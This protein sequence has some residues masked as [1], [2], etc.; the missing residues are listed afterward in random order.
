MLAAWPAT[1]RL[2]MLAIYGSLPDMTTRIAQHSNDLPLC[3]R[4]R[5]DFTAASMAGY[6]C[7]AP[8][9]YCGRLP[10]EYQ[11][12]FLRAIYAVDFY[13]VTSYSTPIA[14]YAKGVWTVP[15]VKYT[16]TTTRHQNI[17]RKAIE[18]IA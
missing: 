12:G 9:G 1:L 2:T 7:P 11:R 14:W 17:V 16:V 10:E 4:I 15:E 18:A 6:A 3:I 8:V 13:V 5:K